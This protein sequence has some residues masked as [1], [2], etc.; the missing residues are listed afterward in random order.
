MNKPKISV[1]IATSIDGYIA[2]KDHSLDW[3]E[4]VGGFDEDYGYKKF[5][6]SIDTLIIGR[7]TYG[8]A[9]TVSDPYPGKRIIVLSR[10]LNSPKE[11]VEVYQGALDELVEKLHNEGTRHVWVDGGATISQFLASQLVDNM[12]ISI[13][14]IILGD[15]LP[16]FNVVGKEIPCRLIG[17]QNYQ[18]GLVQLNYE[19]VK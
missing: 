14:P 17:S 10:T 2:R 1:Y 9:S 3:L 11:G 7:N 16:L 18:S 4:R 12:T 19:I 15:G 13:I 5:L 8:V 6:D